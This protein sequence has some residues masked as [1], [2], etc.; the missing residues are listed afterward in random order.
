LGYVV[1]SRI[2]EDLIASVQSAARGESFI[3]P[4]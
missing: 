2:H 3:S 4:I 1:K